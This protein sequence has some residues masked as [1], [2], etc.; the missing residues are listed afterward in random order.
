MINISIVKP[1]PWHHLILEEDSALFQQI[2]GELETYQFIQSK[3]IWSPTKV[4]N[5]I[6]TRFKGLKD[7]VSPIK[8][9]NN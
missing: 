8:S 9:K 6:I 2:P 3:L 7:P 4:V 1:I 5:K